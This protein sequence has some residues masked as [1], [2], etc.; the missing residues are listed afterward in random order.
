ML[1]PSQKD[2]YQALA[3]AAEKSGNEDRILD[4][5]RLWTISGPRQP[6]PWNRIGEILEKR[7]ELRGALEAY[8][9]SLR[10]EWNQPPTMDAVKRLESALK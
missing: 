1:D 6:L 4:A 7:K 8:K 3:D 5:Y 10:I 2:V 9:K